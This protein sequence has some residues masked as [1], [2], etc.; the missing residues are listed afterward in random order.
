MKTWRAETEF[1]QM[2]MNVPGDDDGIRRPRTPHGFGFARMAMVLRRIQ[3]RSP[4]DHEDA[5]T[6]MHPEPRLYFAEGTQTISL[7]RGMLGQSVRGRN[8]GDEI[9]V[10]RYQIHAYQ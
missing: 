8:F 1:K 2:L 7:G 4:P 6:E 9:G 3:H 10:Q 5:L